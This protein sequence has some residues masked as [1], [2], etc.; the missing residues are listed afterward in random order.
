MLALLAR[1]AILPNTPV[2]I[3]FCWDALTNNV[4]V[5]RYF[6]YRT[7][8]L[9]NPPP[10]T[11]FTNTPGTITLLT[12]NVLPGEAY[13]YVTAS[14]FWECPPSNISMTPGVVGPIQSN[15]LV[16]GATSNRF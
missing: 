8:S 12:V 16:F 4:T 10:W 13:Y 5:D 14:N 11:P 1:A 3:T 2:P 7:T 15:R 9:T 6:I